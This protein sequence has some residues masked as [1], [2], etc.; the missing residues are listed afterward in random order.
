MKMK[1]LLN[2]KSLQSFLIII[3]SVCKN[4]RMINNS[5]K[6]FSTRRV[7]ASPPSTI[8]DVLLK[9]TKTFQSQKIGEPDISTEYIIAHV[10][11]A[12]T[13]HNISDKTQLN[14]SEMAE[15]D[16]L[17]HLRLSRM[18]IQYI[19]GE[20]DFLD[21]TL[22]MRPPVL[23][24][25]PETEGLANLCMKTLS[26]KS[27]TSGMFLEIGPGTGAVSLAMLNKFKKLT[28]VVVDISPVACSLTAENAALVGVN[29]RIQII[30]G[31][32]RSSKVLDQLIKSGPYCLIVS[33]PPYLTMEELK[34]LQPEILHFEDHT[35]LNGGH[36]G[37]DLVKEILSKSNYLLQDKGDIWLEV[38]PHHPN[39]IDRFLKDTN[40]RKSIPLIDVVKD[41]GGKDR[42]CHFENK[43]N[44]T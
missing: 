35:A 31:D 8:K 19:I 34:S 23:I 15:I 44:L 5:S 1:K 25:R 11:G 4:K 6:K 7:V 28:G 29:E 3:P 2:L 13:L 43:K 17:C 38:A 42:F 30:E 32:F 24:P 27:P 21:L 10:L 37:M 14:K 36:D 12:K 16:R 20:W 9:W 18:P 40:L 26:Q 39:L 41:F 22:K 33:N